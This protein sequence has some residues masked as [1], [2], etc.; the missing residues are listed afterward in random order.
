MGGHVNMQGSSHVP[1]MHMQQPQN[2]PP[3]Q[4]TFV[5]NKKIG[6]RTNS[7]LTQSALEWKT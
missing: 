4:N 5:S 6:E 2:T 1:P 3:P 7:H